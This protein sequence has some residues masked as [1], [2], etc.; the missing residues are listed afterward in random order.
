MT[1]LVIQAQTS[2]T[3]QGKNSRQSRK[4][5]V[6]SLPSY[7]RARNGEDRESIMAVM[8]PEDRVLILAET[9]DQNAMLRPP[10]DLQKLN[11]AIGTILTLTAGS[12]SAEQMKGWLKVAVSTLADEPAEALLE[13][14]E[15]AK[16]T[17]KYS[18]E[19]VPFLAKHCENFK[20]PV[21]RHLSVLRQLA[22]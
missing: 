7:E 22:D 12:M 17:V 21:L 19:I 5:C 3:E 11:A 16:R 20:K 1:D 9:Q 10:R 18:N 8:S 13:G 2:M 15:E 4:L 6:M 14:I